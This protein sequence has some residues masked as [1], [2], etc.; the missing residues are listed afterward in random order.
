MADLYAEAYGEA[1]TVDRER[2][3]IT[4]ALFPHLFGN[5]YVYQYATG[6]SAANA[7]AEVVLQEGPSAAERYVRFLSAGDALFPIEALKVAGI[8]MNSPEP[9]ERAFGVLTRMIDRLDQIVG[10]GPLA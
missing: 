4:W 1:V 5:F 10:E 6:I 2:V 9:V 3:G 7:L 8:D